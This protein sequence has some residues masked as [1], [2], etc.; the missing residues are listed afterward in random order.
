MR[1]RCV[2]RDEIGGCGV[3]RRTLSACVVL[4]LW[5]PWPARARAPAALR[6]SVAAEY[7][8][9]V[10]AAGR[11]PLIDRID[12]VNTAVN[13]RVEYAPDERTADGADHWQ[14]PGETLARELGD[15][16]DFAIFKYFALRDCGQPCACARLLYAWRSPTEQPEV[17]RP[18]LVLLGGESLADS[19]VLDNVNRLA[20]PLS[21]RTDLHPVLSFD[22]GHLWRGASAERLGSALAL[23]R[24][25]REVIAR[26][27]QQR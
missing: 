5:A 20:L 21:Q 13:Q 3:L 22:A 2:Q 12:F 19:L 18:H 24:P 14:T 7:D 10:R 25:W 8:A 1:G 27:Q 16:E 11:L 17:R 23:L 15:C 6:P 26:W 9:L 4:G